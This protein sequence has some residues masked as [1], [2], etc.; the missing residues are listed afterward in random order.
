MSWLFSKDS[1]NSGTGTRPTR[2]IPVINYFEQSLTDEEGEFAFDDATGELEFNPLVSPQRPHQSPSVSPRALL[3]PDP[4]EIDEVLEKVNNKLSALP[5]EGE[6]EVVVETG[7]VTGEAN[8]QVC[9]PPPQVIMVDFDAE[10][11][12]DTA[13]A[14][15]NLRSVHCPFNKSDIEFWFSQLED[16]LTLIGVKKQWT[17]KI[18]LSRFLPPEIQTE[19]KSL[20]KLTQTAAGDDIYLKIKARLLKLYGPKPEDSYLRAKSRVLTGKPSQ[21]GKLLVDD[22]CPG[23][24]KLEGCHCARQVWGMFRE[25][26]PIV[27]RNHI[28]DMPFTVDTYEAIFDKAD[29]VFDSNQGS[30]PLTQTVAAVSSSA[31]PE[32]SAVQR[33]QNQK[34]KN[35]GQNKGKNNGGQNNSGSQN[36]PA[37]ASSTSSSKPSTPKVNEDNL[38][39]IHAKWKDNATFCAAPWA[40]RMKNVWKAPQ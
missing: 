36:K 18:A 4:P 6:D 22:I 16:Q 39:R 38:C 5:E 28:A 20:M 10:N 27:I 15:D 17:K 13:T 9:N 32:V 21:L 37:S 26:L 31:S 12:D 29:Q 14:M 35:K 8:L 25:K 1:G 23:E 3:Q 30:E 24:V 7:F 19:V 34:N 11:A 33:G 40:C 2:N